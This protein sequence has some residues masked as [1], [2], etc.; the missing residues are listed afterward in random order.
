MRVREWDPA[1]AS[2]EELEAWLA[3]VNDV[4]PQ[5]L[6]DEPRWRLDKLREYLAVTMPGERR[7]AWFAE[8]GDRVL[9]AAS[10]VLLSGD[11]AVL[12]LMV[13]PEVRR[14]GVGRALLTAVA[15]RVN[16]EGR[17][18]LM[19]EVMSDSG[20]AFYERYGFTRTLVEVRH[21]LS[22]A[23]VDWERTAELAKRVVTGYQVSYH[24]GGP[25]E[26]LLEPY[27]RAKLQLRELPGDNQDID[28]LVRAEADRL[29]C[30]VATLTRRGL[31]PHV[32]VAIHERSGQVAGFTEVVVPTHRP[33]RADQYDT[34]VVRAH[35]GY[36][37][38]LALKARMLLALRET[39]P[40]LVD[41]QTWQTLQM[42]QMA[43]VNAVLGFVPDREWYEYEAEVP[44]LLSRLSAT[45]GQ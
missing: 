3:L 27:A 9:G 36:G 43:R 14:E 4:L 37:L 32:A 8:S 6:P 21:L 15:W 44:S 17:R 33:E 24:P 34:L 31:R 12:D 41:M 11:T 22:M 29:R 5:D 18:T 30:S 16:A 20:V 23:D 38:G 35:R 10:V 40:Q 39:E 42:E 25:P 1:S 7:I 19:V 2:I 45:A 28:E 26:E 13:H